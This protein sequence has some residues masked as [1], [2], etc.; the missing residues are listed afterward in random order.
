MNKNITELLDKLKELKQKM[1]I[2]YTLTPGELYLLV[3][4][5]EFLENGK[6]DI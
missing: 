2:A 3:E 6:K 5:I 4:Y 1:T